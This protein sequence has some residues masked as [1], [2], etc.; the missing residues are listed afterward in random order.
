MSAVT[1]QQSDGPDVDS[2]AKE[3]AQRLVRLFGPRRARKL[4]FQASAWLK[5][6]YGGDHGS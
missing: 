6:E 4:T 5:Y 2:Q 1:A 3:L